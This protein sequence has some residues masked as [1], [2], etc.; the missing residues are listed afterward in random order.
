MRN[1]HL[2]DDFLLIIGDLLLNLESGV[3]VTIV[4]EAKG[5][6]I[7]FDRPVQLVEIK[8]DEA[9][10]LASSL[11]TGVYRSSITDDLRTLLSDRYFL[12]PRSLLEVRTQLADKG[13]ITTSSILSTLLARMVARSELIRMGVVKRFKYSSNKKTRAR[14]F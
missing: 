5:K 6:S 4:N 10:R 14:Q 3:S 12:T 2:L 1:F 13:T 7:R 9:S 11:L 8:E